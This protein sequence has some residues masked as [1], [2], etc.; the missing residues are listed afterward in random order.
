LIAKRLDV[1]FVSRQLGHANANVTLSVYA[2]LFAQ[3][4][5]AE[6][7]RQ[8]LEASYPAMRDVGQL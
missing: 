8:A 1:V 7:E 4:E 2:H 3:R 6:A 5:H